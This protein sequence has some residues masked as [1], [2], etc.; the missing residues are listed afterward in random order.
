ML[1]DFNLPINYMHPKSAV[2]IFKKRAN[3]SYKKVQPLKVYTNSIGVKNKR[4]EYIKKYLPFHKLDIEGEI[5]IMYIDETS[6]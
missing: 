4:K 2:K 5:S 1:K 6:F 3:F